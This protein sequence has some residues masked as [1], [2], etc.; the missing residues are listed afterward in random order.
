ME[1]REGLGEGKSERE[2]KEGWEGREKGK[3]GE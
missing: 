3:L 2:G 1:G